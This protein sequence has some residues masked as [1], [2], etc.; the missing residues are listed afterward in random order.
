MLSRYVRV[1]VIAGAKRE[2]LQEIKGVLHIAVKE[3]A[4][5]NQANS[6]V[7]SL[8]ARHLGLAPR[9]VAIHTGHHKPFK[10]LVVR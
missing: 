3:K 6:K 4:E 10:L 5:E 7:L 9:Q 8:V 1:K 2:S